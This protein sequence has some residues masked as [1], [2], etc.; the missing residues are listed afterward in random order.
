LREK[1]LTTPSPRA[2]HWIAAISCIGVLLL[3]GS[4][5]SQGWEV[6]PLESDRSTTPIDGDFAAD[7]VI[8]D[9]HEAFVKQ[10]STLRERPDHWPRLH[11]AESTQRRRRVH[12]VI[13]FRGCAG[14]D[15]EFCSMTLDFLV[16]RPDGSEYGA[17]K[18]RILWDGNEPPPDGRLFYVG[19]P[20]LEFI[21][22][23]EDPL[24]DYEFIAIIRSPSAASEIVLKRRLTVVK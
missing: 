16:R 10:W 22:E 1:K 20:Y 13:I 23:E 21:P 19:G 12:A 17:A 4:T 2:R 18:G 7:L 8:T 3:L 11:L 5:I 9:Q 14:S 15:D 24:G 6:F